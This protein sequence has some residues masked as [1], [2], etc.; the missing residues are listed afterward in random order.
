MPFSR[1][2]RLSFAMFKGMGS[3]LTSTVGLIFV[4]AF[5]AKGLQNVGIVDLLLNAAQGLGVGETGVG[6]VLSII[7]GVITVL[8]GSGVASFTSLAPIVSDVA[9]AMGTAG[10]S[11]VLMM[12]SAAEML[13]AMSPVAGVVI[14]VA[15]FAQVTPLTMVKRTAIPC[16]VGFVVMLTVVGLFF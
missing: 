8:T 3:I 14:I 12:H 16:L 9:Q 10:I 5:F 1:F 7:I 6:V 11:M 15:G 2:F 4:A 13:R